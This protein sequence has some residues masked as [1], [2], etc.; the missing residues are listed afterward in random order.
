MV[1][2]FFFQGRQAIGLSVGAGLL[3]A[4]GCAKHPEA[5]ASPA[6]A[7]S[8][9]VLT[10]PAAGAPIAATGA[11]RREREMTLSFRIPGVIT[12]LGFDEGDRVARGQTI[13]A[14]DPAAVDAKARQTAADLE[15]ARRDAT[16]LSQLV[17]RGAIS[18]QQFEA[19]STQVTDAQAAYDAAAFD[20]R[21]A[22][23]SAPSAGVVLTR[24]AQVGEVVQ[25]GQAIVSFADDTSPFVLWLALSDR[26]IGKVRLGAPARVTLDALP[27][28][29]LTGRVTRIG[30]HAGALSG[31]VEVEVTLPTRPELRSG[32]IAHAEIDPA[33][34]PGDTGPGYARAPAET[35]LEVNGDRAVVMR[36]DPATQTAVRTPVAFGG[37]DGDQALLAGLAAG[38]RLIAAGAGFVSDGEKVTVID[39]AALPGGGQRP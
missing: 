35:V 11:L 27:G 39:P 24:T 3:V 2:A 1:T 5:A 12:R 8:V 20:R 29:G 22:T 36:L 21:W 17:D 6:P 25:P 10:A 32:L 34:S 37:F 38:T 13:A 14:L 33:P 28:Q 26:D 19:Q 30:E 7:V 18:R 31:S 4:A 16:R 15:R 23:L 9:A